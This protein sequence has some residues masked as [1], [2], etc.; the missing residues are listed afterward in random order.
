MRLDRFNGIRLKVN[1]HPHGPIQ[2]YDLDADPG[3]VVDVAADHPEG[4]ERIEQ[5]MTASHVPSERFRFGA[6]K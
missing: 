6:E 3:E 4:V 1:E 5:A 2:L